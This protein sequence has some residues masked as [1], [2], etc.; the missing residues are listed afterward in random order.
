M[1]ASGS[2]HERPSPSS[3][4]AQPVPRRTDENLKLVHRKIDRNLKSGGPLVDNTPRVDPRSDRPILPGAP[5]LMARLV[6]LAGARAGVDVAGGAAPAPAEASPRTVVAGAAAGAPDDEDD[7][8]ARAREERMAKQWEDVT[9]RLCRDFAPGGGAE[10]EAVLEHIAHQRRV[11]DSAT[12]R[13]YLPVLVERA[14][15]RLLDPN[16]AARG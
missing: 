2:A 5:T 9:A 6:Q 10:V 16:E 8:L 7:F 4:W 11:L 3:R 15:R 1:T 14:V 12:V 13:D